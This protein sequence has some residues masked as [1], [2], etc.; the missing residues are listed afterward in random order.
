MKLFSY[1]SKL[2]QTLMPVGDLI[3]LNIMYIVFCLPIFTI[4][5]AQAGLYSGVKV[6]LD[7]EDDSSC[8]A[9]FFKGFR[10]GFG[11]ITLS[12]VI[13]LILLV[14]L[15]WGLIMVLVYQYAGAHA[16]VWMSVTAVCICA[17]FQTLLPIFHARFDC[18]SWQ[19]VRNSWFLVIAHPLRS[20]AVT[21]L[22]WLP[23]VVLL[24]NLYLF[25][26]M[27]PIWLCGY[28][29]IAHMLSFIIM[30]KPFQVLI[31]HITGADGEGEEAP[32]EAAEEST[33]T[34]A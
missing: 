24:S 2:M 1:E 14:P 22:I 19:L 3:I 13:F 28:Y 8:A 34:E 32:E 11:K 10:T 5:A 12:W 29:S 18:T 7:K 30:K 31:D 6:L 15:L 17:V 25:M 26:L 33:E 16:P 4:G 21:V 27:T 23:L 9:A 20:I